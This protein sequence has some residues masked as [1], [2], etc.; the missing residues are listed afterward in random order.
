MPNPTPKD[1]D[2]SADKR[3]S[4]RKKAPES[5]PPALGTVVLFWPFLLFHGLIKPLPK[6]L[7]FPVRFFGD[8]GI[9]GLY[10]GLIMGTFYYARAQPFDM[11]KVA[12]M[13]QR[14]IVYDRRG[15]ELGRIHG[16][17]RDVINISDVSQHFIFAILAREDK[18]FYKHHGVD[19]VGVARAMV[20]NFKRRKVDQGASTLTMQLAR[21]SFNLKSKWLD[22]S[23]KLQELDRKLLEAAVSYRIESAY[24][25]D[26]GKQEILQHYLNRIF[27]GH[28]IRGLEEA[29][30]TYFEKSAKDLTLS[31]SALLAGI[32]RGPNAFSPFKTIDGAK[33]ERDTTLDRMVAEQFITQEEADTAKK[34]E[35]NIRPEWRRTFH[36]SYAMDAITRELLRILEEE[37][38][39]MGGL[40]VTTTIDNLIQKKAEEALDAKLRQVERSPGYPHQTRSKWKDLPE[41]DR[42]P[43]EYLQGSVVA[44]ENLTGAVLAVVGGRNA[45]ES[46]FN[47]ALQGRRQIGSVFK[48]FV[49]LAA[50]DEGLRPDTLISD[51]PLYRGEIKKAGTWSP[52][53]SDGKYGGMMPAATGLIR[54]RNTMSVRVGNKAGIDKVADTALSVGFETP[55]PKSPISFLGSW[56]ATTYEVASAYTVF[57]NGGTRHPPR[58]I[59]EI[60]D[61][62]GNI[63]YKADAVPYEATRSGSAWSVS[64]ILREVTERGTA[65]SVKSL[66]FSKPCGGKTGTTNEYRD[67]WFAGYTS[68]ITCA[69]W[70]GLDTPKKTIDRGYGSTLAL[71]VWVEVMKTADKLG[72]KAEGLKSQLSFVECRLCRESGK[73]ATNGCELDGE[74]YT[75]NVPADIVP[76]E[77][78]LCP[79]HPAKALAVNEDAPASEPMRATP[80]DDEAPMRAQP[81]DEGPIQEEEEA[82]LKAIPV[83]EE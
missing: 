58:I 65:A 79:I 70:V 24:S 71:P 61:R 40:K 76:A 56:E 53:N 50:F 68:S 17:K 55:M 14:T 3:S 27:L 6:F 7:R 39:E 32:V 64:K 63:L 20:E 36:H 57:P 67:A 26:E 19:W 42:P 80:V 47:R 9:A 41:G 35:V 31:E 59:D 51:G 30:R 43:P 44:I 13:P 23:P 38:I 78:D 12:E 69:V 10:V 34:E 16:E 1:P 54:S 52:Q 8:L 60:R 29:S 22:F 15:E 81:V 49:Y 5:K 83:E 66:G 2:K 62:E 33:R 18:R 46:K 11:A 73:R 48:P 82:P 28:N 25:G 75:D 77:N 74:A 72:Y 45:D 21:N 4:N 37:N